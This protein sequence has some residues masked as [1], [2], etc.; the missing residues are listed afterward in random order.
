[1]E[2]AVCPSLRGFQVERNVEDASHCSGIDQDPLFFLLFDFNNQRQ[3]PQKTSS[4]TIPFLTHI[5][6]SQTTVLYT[7]KLLIAAS[8]ILSSASAFAPA[9]VS[10]SPS[11]TV[12][13]VGAVAGTKEKSR[14]GFT[15]TCRHFPPLVQHLMNFFFFF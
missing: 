2:A 8:F 12:S 9:A 5:T 13:V 11:T 4:I 10:Q 1:L 6:N 14:F 7:M 15:T 3:Q